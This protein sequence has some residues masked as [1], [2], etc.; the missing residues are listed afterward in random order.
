MVILF[1]PWPQHIKGYHYTISWLAL[2]LTRHSHLCPLFLM[3][4]FSSGTFSFFFV[5]T[6]VFRKLIMICFDVV[7]LYHAWGMLILVHLWV[8]SFYQIW[9][10]SGHISSNIYIYIYSI[11]LLFWDSNYTYIRMILS[12]RS[13][14]LC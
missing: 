9:K 7:C 5:F 14:R 10:K 4:L 1:P 13:L 6:L 8:Y 12:H 3:C 11:L 2:L